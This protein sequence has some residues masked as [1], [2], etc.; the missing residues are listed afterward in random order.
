M[1]FELVEAAV[2]IAAGDVELDVDKVTFK[3]QLVPARRAHRL[4]PERAW[5]QRGRH[6]QREETAR[7]TCRINTRVYPVCSPAV[8]VRW[9]C[10]QQSCFIVCSRPKSSPPIKDAFEWELLHPQVRIRYHFAILD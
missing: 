6:P 10:H 5:R 8:Y 7:P 4:P 9:H 1:P 2:L 3:E